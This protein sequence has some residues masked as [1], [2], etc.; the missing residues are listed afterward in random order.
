MES[1]CRGSTVGAVGWRLRGL[2]KG[3]V[4]RRQQRSGLAVCQG[5]AGVGLGAALLSRPQPR[6]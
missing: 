4:D 6:L 3:P 5:L 2:G 1:R